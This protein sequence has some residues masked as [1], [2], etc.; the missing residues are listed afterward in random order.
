MELFHEIF[1]P[2]LFEVLRAPAPYCYR[3]PLKK[4]RPSCGIACAS[5]AE[6]I[7]DERGHEIA[8]LVI[9]P[10]VQ[11]AAGMITQPPGYLKRLEAACRRNDVLLICDEV[12]TGF[13]RTGSLFAVEQ[14]GVKPDLLC[15]A[16]GLTGGYLPLAATLAT[17]QVFAAFSGPFES[18]R[19]LFHGH[20]YT[21]NPLACAAALASLALLDQDRTVEHVQSLL[22]QLQRGLARIAELPH[23]GEVRQAGMMVGIE[24]VRERA[25][26]SEYAYA[27][28][29][30]HQVIL[31]ARKRGVVLRPLG[32]VIVLMPPLSIT[33][34]EL[35]L[36]L[37]VTHDSIAQVTS[38]AERA[39]GS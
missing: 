29:L 14:E 37:D 19:T 23:V 33:T 12:A 39:A 17:E 15:L 24:L 28:R 36:L 5:E 2:L 20:T 30:G 6:T 9:E 1:R 32:N 25:T 21:G 34:D 11:G 31:E 7:L 18:R 16:K 22:P 35:Q 13:G 10:G 8:A 3:C 26:R 4:E 27:D 38:A